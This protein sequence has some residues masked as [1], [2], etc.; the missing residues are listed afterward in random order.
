MN[1]ALGA[2]ALLERV[3]KGQS[4]AHDADRL[5]QWLFPGEQTEIVK[6]YLLLM[7]NADKVKGYIAA[8]LRLNLVASLLRSEN[9]AMDRLEVR[10]LC[11]DAIRQY[12]EYQEQLGYERDEACDAAVDAVI[13]EL[14]QTV[15]RIQEGEA[16]C[17]H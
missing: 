13:E 4:D 11:I 5:R 17:T 12:D 8:D 3:A 7:G 10:R 14:R 9:D 16:W 2:T 6:A 1:A 15:E